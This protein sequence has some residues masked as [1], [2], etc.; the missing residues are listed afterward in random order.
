MIE[1]NWDY[2]VHAPLLEGVVRFGAK[3]ECALY[4]KVLAS[5]ANRMESQ[6]CERLIVC[7]RAR[8]DLEPFREGFKA[9]ESLFH[10]SRYC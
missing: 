7:L 1:P 10:K 5:E 8:Q 2:F 3:T 9:K 6:S 4:A